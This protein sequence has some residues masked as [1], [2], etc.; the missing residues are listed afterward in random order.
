MERKFQEL[1]NE[2][3]ELKER[4]RVLEQGSPSVSRKDL[5]GITGI[6]S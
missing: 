1:E 2:V 6:I 5:K 4:V 3:Q